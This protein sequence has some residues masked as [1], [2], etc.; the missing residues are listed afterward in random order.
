MNKKYIWILGDQLFENHPAAKIFSKKEI[1]FLFIESKFFSSRFN[2]HPIKIEFL[3]ESMR[4]YA[5]DLKR[6]G[7]EV[8]YFKDKDLKEV[9]QKKKINKLYF[10]KTANKETEGL[11]KSAK[12]FK[13]RSGTFRKSIISHT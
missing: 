12:R 1:V 7:F 3:H 6:K 2:Y 8:L 10:C 11:F 9:F 4:N 5:G 13:N